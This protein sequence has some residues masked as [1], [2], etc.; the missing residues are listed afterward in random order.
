MRAEQATAQGSWRILSIQRTGPCRPNDEPP[1]PTDSKNHP[2]SAG[3]HPLCLAPCRGGGGQ[4]TFCAGRSPD[5]SIQDRSV[6]ALDDTPTPPIQKSPASPDRMPFCLAPCRAGGKM[7]L[8]CGFAQTDR[9]STWT[10]H[11]QPAQMQ[12]MHQLYRSH[13]ACSSFLSFFFF[14]VTRL[15]DRNQATLTSPR[16][17]P[18]RGW[19]NLAS[20]T[21]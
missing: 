17:G 11:P 13:E 7:T 1:N 6:P 16:R 21:L 14:G 15:Q 8:L 18:T 9:V 20:T 19:C 2:A 4:M 10:E 5:F 3:S 12:R